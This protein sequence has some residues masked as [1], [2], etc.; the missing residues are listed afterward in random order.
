MGALSSI[1]RRW[2]ILKFPKNLEIYGNRNS[3]INSETHIT[4]RKKN[5]LPIVTETSGEPDAILTRIGNGETHQDRA[6]GIRLFSQQTPS[7]PNDNGNRHALEI[8]LKM[9]G[10]AGYMRM[11]MYLVMLQG[12]SL[13]TSASRNPEQVIRLTEHGHA[14]Q[15]C[16]ACR[17]C[18][19]S[20][21]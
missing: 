13:G 16:G 5:Y 21:W 11:S 20:F 2:A 8:K 9:A 4:G 6:G 19:L 15:L 3:V 14:F 18:W 12:R 7:K 10:A 1:A 17:G